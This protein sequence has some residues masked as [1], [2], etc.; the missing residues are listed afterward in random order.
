MPN[1]IPLKVILNAQIK[2]LKILH[3]YQVHVEIIEV[4][5]F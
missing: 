5:P 1:E 2:T 3:M 4:A